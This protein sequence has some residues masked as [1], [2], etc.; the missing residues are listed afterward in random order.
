[1]K[2]Y[3]V[4]SSWTSYEIPSSYF[5]PMCLSEDG[6]FIGFDELPGMSKYNV[7][8]ELILRF[9]RPCDQIGY[10]SYTVY[11]ESFLI[12]ANDGSEEKEG[13][14]SVKGTEESTNLAT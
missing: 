3:N 10:V 4:Q 9:D 8:G 14:S 6:D 7:R 12:L 1:M 11:T 13:S 5:E 2:E